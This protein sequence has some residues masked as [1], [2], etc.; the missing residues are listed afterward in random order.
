MVFHDPF[1][2]R[3][4]ASTSRFYRPLITKE[5]LIKPSVHPEPFIRSH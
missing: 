3:L 1:F 5:A 4:Y 2:F